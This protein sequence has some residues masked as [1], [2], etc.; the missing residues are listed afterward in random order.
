M[1]ASFSE[2]T[3]GADSKSNDQYRAP[4]HNP[5]DQLLLILFK[6]CVLLAL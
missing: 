5:E 1:L 4:V 3:Y 2:K 6:I